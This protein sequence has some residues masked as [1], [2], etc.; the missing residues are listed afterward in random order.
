MSDVPSRREE[1]LD[2]PELERAAA[3]LTAGTFR[4]SFLQDARGALAAAGVTG[5][6]APLVDYLASMSSEELA[7]VAELAT[8]LK[9][10][11]LPPETNN[12]FM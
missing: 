4:Q 12:C 7:A 5:L 6:P 8:F 9:G 11:R 2:C 10:F 3:L 1:V